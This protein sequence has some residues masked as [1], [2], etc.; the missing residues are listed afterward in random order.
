[1]DEPQVLNGG[2][3]LTEFDNLQSKKV[4]GLYVCG[5]ASGVFGYC[6]GYNLQYAWSSGAVVAKHIAG[7]K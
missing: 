6:G 7:D 4:A 1:M 2:F 3:N 5:E